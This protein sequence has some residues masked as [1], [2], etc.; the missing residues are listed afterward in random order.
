VYKLK[1]TIV[2]DLRILVRDTVGL[3]LMFVMPIILV[4]VVTMIQNSTY[5]LINKNRLSLLLCNRD[6]GEASRQL[7]Q[8]IDRIGMFRVVPV[9]PGETAANIIARMHKKDA[10]LSIIIP[11][12]FS[13]RITEKAK[14]SSGQAMKAFGLDADSVH[15]TAGEALPVTLYYHPVLQEPLRKS[16]DGALRSALQIVETRQ[17][18]KTL[19]FSING[20]ALPDTL[21]KALLHSNTV[22]TEIPVSRD[23]NLSIPNASQHNAPAWTIFAMF[24]IVMSLGGS[25][26]REKSSGSFVRLKTLPTNYALSLLSKQLTYLAVTLLQ[27]AVIFAL[28]VW[29]FPAIGL[30]ALN[31]PAD[32]GALLLVTLVCGWCAVTYAICV[33]VFAGTQEQA[34]G[35]GAVSIV[36]LSAIG[37]LMVPA[38]GMPDS[39]H[40]I[41]KLSPMHWGLEAYYDL[42]LEGGTLRDVW[43]NL[44]PLLVITVILQG[45][46][47]AGLKRKKLI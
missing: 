12:D 15:T 39:F 44:I 23:G 6:T 14:I 19:Y 29:L 18:L 38:V 47:V 1:A 8:S 40:V 3:T 21:E 28:G 10:Y 17:M 16:V 33:G 37:G 45:V 31:M 9:A 4:V 26:V 34:N 11:A 41:M 22:I 27:A 43:S 2:K 46:I 25:I 32:I 5:E 30:P 24:F 35:F 13:L 7:V 36:I 20:T 42:F